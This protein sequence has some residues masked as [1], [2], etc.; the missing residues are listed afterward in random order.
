[1]LHVEGTMSRDA[2]QNSQTVI[3][4]WEYPT[5]CI[6][7]GCQI[8]QGDTIFPKEIQYGAGGGY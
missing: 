6:I 8:S 5:M 7:L 3:W 4:G 2:P 1:M